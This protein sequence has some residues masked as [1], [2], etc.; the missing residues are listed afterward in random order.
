MRGGTPL[1]E[2]RSHMEDDNG[3]RITVRG[4]LFADVCL[5]VGSRFDDSVGLVA[6]EYDA[7][8]EGEE[9]LRQ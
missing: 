2:V 4:C 7:V 3:A 5:F 9:G 8:R 1:T 6:E